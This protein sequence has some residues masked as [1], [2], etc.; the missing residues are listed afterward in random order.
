MVLLSGFLLLCSHPAVA[1]SSFEDGAQ[2]GANCWSIVATN[3]LAYGGLLH[4]PKP[5]RYPKDFS[6][7]GS[8]GRL[9]YLSE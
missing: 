9:I 6:G 2:N 8:I 5:R 3:I 7:K 4:T 1:H